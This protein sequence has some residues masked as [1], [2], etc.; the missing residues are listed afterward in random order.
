MRLKAIK[1]SDYLND[2]K[3]TIKELKLYEALEYLR[4]EL[5]AIEGEYKKG[6]YDSKSYSLYSK[7]EWEKNNLN[8]I[9]ALKEI[10]NIKEEERYL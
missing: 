4:G 8:A 7:S 10:I 2:Y 1:K 6:Y 3:D 5:K 9:K